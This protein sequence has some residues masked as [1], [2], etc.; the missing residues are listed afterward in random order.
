M[1]NEY[2]GMFWK[3]PILITYKLSAYIFKSTPFR[4]KRKSFAWTEDRGLPHWTCFWV[5]A[6]GTYQ[7]F[8]YYIHILIKHIIQNCS[9]QL[10]EK[11]FLRNLSY[12]TQVRIYCFW[13]TIYF[14]K[15]PLFTHFLTKTVHYMCLILQIYT[16]WSDLRCISAK[17]WFLGSF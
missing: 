9:Q 6:P 15:K 16:G 1:R 12:D 10:C 2:A 8:F 4:K 7:T 13:H 14:S 5:L 11:L 3:F 17:G